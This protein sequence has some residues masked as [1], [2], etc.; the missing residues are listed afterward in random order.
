MR[1][2]ILC[3]ALFVVLTL[4]GCFP[5]VATGVVG[6][7]ALMVDDRRTSGIYIEDE[8]IEWKALARI[9]QK[10]KDAHVNTTSFNLSVLV[11]GE[12]PTEAMKNEIADTVR[13]IPSVRNVTNEIAVAGNSSLTSRGN[14]TLISTSVKSRFIGNSRFSPNHVKVVTEAGVVYLMGLVTQ[15]EGDGAAESARTTSGVARVVK[16]FEYVPEPPKKP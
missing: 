14:D 11:T 6:A 5:L 16:V 9:G 1:T 2:L 13:A 8:N 10:F 7:T 15:A 3:F 4:Q 12:A